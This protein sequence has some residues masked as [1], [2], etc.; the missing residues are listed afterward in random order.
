MIY[1]QADQYEDLDSE[2]K[3]LLKK[4]TKKDPHTRE[5]VGV[6]IIFF[7]KKDLNLFFKKLKNL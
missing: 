1:F 6:F 3:V 2:A 7:L 4:L 5:K